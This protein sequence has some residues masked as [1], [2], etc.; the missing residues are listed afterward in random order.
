[1]PYSWFIAIVLFFASFTLGI[2]GFGFALVSMPFLSLF[3]SPKF[4]VPFVMLYGYAINFFL[5]LR[6]REYIEWRRLWPLLVGGLPGIPLGIYFLKNFEDVWIKKIVGGVVIVFALWNL[7]AR[8]ERRYVLSRFWAYLAGFASGILSGGTAMG[9]PPVLIY[10][11][12]NRWEK[13]LTRAT[14][15]SFFFTMMTCSL[16]GLAIT[17]VLTLSVLRFNLLYLPTV[18]LG[19]ITGY[20]L[21][22]RLASRRFHRILLCL[23]LV[24]GLLL[25]FT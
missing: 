9:G 22:T 18:I 25:V 15:Q 10:L 3:V 24:I 11:T 2:A 6:F 5:L 1:M 17:K 14:L 16:S 21:F 4:A 12:L 8:T 13:T 19:A 7:I 20:L 23:L